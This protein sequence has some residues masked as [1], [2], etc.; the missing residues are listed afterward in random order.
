MRF[1]IFEPEKSGHFDQEH[2]SKI[3]FGFK[4]IFSLIFVDAQKA[5]LS[6]FELTES[7]FSFSHMTL[8]STEKIFD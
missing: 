5:H 1:S 2:L 6:K 3:D 8:I 4:N 7:N